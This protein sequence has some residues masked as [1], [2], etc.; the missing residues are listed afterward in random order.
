[1]WAEITAVALL[2][3]CGYLLYRLI[4]LQRGLSLIEGLLRD[5]IDGRLSRRLYLQQKDSIQKVASLLHTLVE[6][7]ASITEDA[8]HKGYSLKAVLE[9]IPDGVVLL[10]PDD[11]IEA[12][13]PAFKAVAETTG[14]IQGR[15][16]TEV[17][18]VPEVLR[19]LDRART[20]KGIVREEFFHEDRQR[21][22]EVIACPLKIERGGY[23]PVVLI[24]RDITEI[25]RTD[26]I[27]RDFVANVSHELKTPITTI[28]GYTETLLEGAVDDP[29]TAEQFLRTVLSYSERMENLVN[30]LIQLSKIESG[31]FKIQKAS[32]LLREVFEEA[33]GV[34]KRR[35]EDRGLLLRWEVIPE[36]LSI[37][38]DPLRLGQILHNLLDNAVKFTEEGEVTLKAYQDS[39]GVIIEVADTGPGVPRW[40]LPRLGERFFRVDPSRSRQLGGTG[41]GLA[42]VK[43]LVLAHGWQIRFDS[44]PHRGTIVR[45]MVPVG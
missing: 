26:Q 11:R 20:G 35:A 41:L 23:P 43:H 36:D 13:N 6:Q 18:R 12:H 29:E 22:Y 33:C 45:I 8:S 19:A 15:R 39:Q 17:C 3:F 30:D 40:A 25:K 28:K 4:S 42:I 2:L 14:Q 32:V 27:R 38:A 24:F 37:E 10:G 44:Q 21:H 1:M 7:Y 5:Y 34:F 31:A 9:S 16:L